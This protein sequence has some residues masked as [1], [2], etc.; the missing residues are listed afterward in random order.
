MTVSP[1]APKVI[2]TDD[3]WIL[4]ATEPPLTVEKLKAEVVDSHNWPGGALWWSIG[5]HEVYHYETEIGE[6]IGEAIEGLDEGTYS[7]VHSGTPGVIGKIA[8]NVRALMDECG[9]PVTALSKLCREAGLPFFPRVRMSSHYEIDPRNPAYGRFRRDNPE[10]LIGKP[11][12]ELAV[13]SLPWGQR[14][15]LNYAFPEVREYMRRIIFETFERFDVDGVE[16][17]Y[18]RHP[19]VFR[20]DEAY[21]NRYL[22]T[23]LIERVRDRLKEVGAE[24]G[25][26]LQLAVRVPPTLADSVRIGLDVERWIRDGL[27]D[28][29][30]VGGGFIPF[31]TPIR[32]FVEAAEDSGCLIY[33]CIEATRHMD[34]DAVRALAARWLSHGAAGVYLY[35]FYTIYPEWNQRIAEEVSDPS[36]LERLNK[37]YELDR[38]GP[39]YPSRGHGGAFRYASPSTTLPVTLRSTSEGGGPEFSIEV[40]DDLGSAI[41]DNALE[42]CSLTLRFEDISP[43]DE[44]EVTINGTTLARQSGGDAVDGWTRMGITAH[45]WMEYPAYPEERENEGK[46]LTFEAACPPLRQG[47]NAIGVSLVPSGGNAGSVATLTN[48]ELD[49]AYKQ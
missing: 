31:E 30:A 48:V 29:V 16:L 34:D 1:D 24:R 39:L 27:V 7:F 10:L 28:I 14:T 12:E 42:G 5:D 33:G 49:V 11:G 4:S 37:R 46:S 20:S 17:D 40:T 47:D 23:D 15:G 26:D 9:G 21:Q 19:G 2:F 8:A 45:F 25:R 18:M 35:N 22:M 6:I 44:I 3:G 41:S 13:G 32:E 43:D 38:A 36:R